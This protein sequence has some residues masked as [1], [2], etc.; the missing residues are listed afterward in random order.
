[1]KTVEEL[2]ADP[3][4]T[5]AEIRLK[6]A[7]ITDAWWE[8]LLVRVV[9]L[10]ARHALITRETMKEA[11]DRR[12]IL[13]KKLHI[14]A[15]DISSDNEASEYYPRYGGA[16]GLQPILRIGQPHEG[17]LSL[18]GWLIECAEHLETGTSHDAVSR[19][20]DSR[21]GVA[22]EPFVIRG[23]FYWI[24]H[25]LSA[26]LALKIVT[27]LPPTTKVTSLLAGAFL[28]KDI[29]GNHVTS[30]RRKERPTNYKE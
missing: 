7:G 29:S 19:P 4:T 25:Y 30:L 28:D 10:P 3:R 26:G 27:K 14:L 21:V 23:I 2:K 20:L 12:R 8:G 24:E 9:A 15:G 22:F 6:K 5:D 1:M 18:A 11:Q 17:A 13:A 16:N